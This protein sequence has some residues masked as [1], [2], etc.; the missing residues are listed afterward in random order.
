MTLESEILT[1]QIDL[2]IEMSHKKIAMV[3]P[4]VEI[5]LS[6][7][8]GEFDIIWIIS[9]VYKM[10]FLIPTSNPSYG[11][12]KVSLILEGSHLKKIDCAFTTAKIKPSNRRFIQQNNFFWVTKLGLNCFP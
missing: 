1:N 10:A 11:L 2:I 8:H 12:D 6:L 7:H 4:Y 3:R 5:I 9:K